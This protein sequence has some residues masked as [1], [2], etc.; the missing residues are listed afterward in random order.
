MNF[1]KLIKSFGF[2]GKGFVSL[3]KSENNFQFHF[4][5]M[6]VVLVCGFVFEISK[7]EWIV[8]LILFALVFSAE[9]FNTGLEKLC[10]FVH[11]DHHH[12]IG[13]IKDIA[14]A[15]VL[16]VAIVSAVIGVLIFYPK[17]F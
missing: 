8:V 4:V 3:L 1:K 2:A 13:I 11:P 17:V 5:A 16:I 14:A 10:D 6:L 7:V 9:A 15:G 12:K